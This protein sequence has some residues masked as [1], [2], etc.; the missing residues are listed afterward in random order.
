[1][2]RQDPSTPRR[3]R[4]ERAGL[5][6]AA[7]LKAARRLDAETLT[8]QSLAE[9]LG[10]DRKALHHH[11][12]SRDTL[13]QMLAEDAFAAGMSRTTIAADASWQDAC[14]RFAEGVRRS[15]V[16]SGPLARHVRSS[17]AL[18]LAMMR[19]AESV[20]ERMRA[21]GFPSSTAARALLLL[22]TI[23]TGFARDE[24][25]AVMR[26]V[27]PQVERFRALVDDASPSELSALRTVDRSGFDPFGDEQFAFDIAAFLAGVEAQHGPAADR[28]DSPTGEGP[29]A[30]PSSGGGQA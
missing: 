29:S 14:R 25:A 8:M 7:I 30:T 13:L 11:V 19:P 17:P 26:G 3:G 4:G 22:T 24:I 2:S 9:S 27:H 28:K 10:V 6:R 5:D 16:G 20:L 15:L 21:A 18:T 23:S 12:D 1:M